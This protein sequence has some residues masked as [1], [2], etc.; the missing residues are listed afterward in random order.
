M[1]IYGSRYGNERENAVPSYTR[2]SLAYTAP[3]R[4]PHNI[5][6]NIRCAICAFSA[7]PRVNFSPRKK[8]KLTTRQMTGGKTPGR[9]WA[10]GRK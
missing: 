9:A 8:E 7:G 2:R 1:Y 4:V 5:R 10:Y 3:Y 6:Y